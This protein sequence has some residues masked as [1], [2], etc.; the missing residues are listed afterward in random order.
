MAS[1]I[2]KVKNIVLDL[3]SDGKEHSSEEMKILIQKDGIELDKKSNVLRT[4]IYQMRSS[5]IRIYSRDRGV[6]QILE[7][8]EKEEAPFLQEFTT[9]LPE[10]KNSPKCIYVHSDGSL[11]FNG[12]LNGEIKS[13][14]I[15]IRISDDGKRIVLIPDG[16]NNHKFTKSGRTKNTELIRTLKKKHIGVPATFEMERYMDSEI[17]IGEI[18][19]IKKNKK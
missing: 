9:L 5:G 6:Y 12:K 7:N 4:A 3:L 11:N 2:A 13:R 10:E 18:I 19:K 17:W 14:Q 8:V 15:E 16:K 1:K